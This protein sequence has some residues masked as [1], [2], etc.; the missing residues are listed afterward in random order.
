MS[1]IE[2]IYNFMKVLTK[3]LTDDYYTQYNN[4]EPFARWNLPEEIALEWIDAEGMIEILSKEGQLSSELETLLTKIKDNFSSA[5]EDN[6]NVY[7]HERMITGEFWEN[8][9]KLAKIALSLF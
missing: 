1:S 6:L 3:E 7:T 4:M 2:E 9:R 5:F 8:Q